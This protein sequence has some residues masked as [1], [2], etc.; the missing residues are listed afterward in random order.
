[1]G[2][3]YTDC[4]LDD[5]RDC[6]IELKPIEGTSRHRLNIPGLRLTIRGELDDLS[7]LGFEIFHL[8]RREQNRKKKEMEVVEEV[9]AEK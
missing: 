8:T 6:T 4:I 5:Q 2:W 9:L 7:I 3:T 1:M